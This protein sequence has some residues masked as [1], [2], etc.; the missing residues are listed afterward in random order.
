MRDFLELLCAF[1]IFSCLI[2]MAAYILAMVM[3]GFFGL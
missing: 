3:G 1:G 2:I